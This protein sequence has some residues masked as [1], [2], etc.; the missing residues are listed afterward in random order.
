MSRLKQVQIAEAVRRAISQIVLHEL[1]DPRIGIL[2]ITAVEV[3]SDLRAARVHV[4]VHGSEGDRTKALHGL[5]HARGFIQEQIAKR[6]TLRYIP[7]LRFELDDSA[8]DQVRLQQ[9][10]EEIR[11]EDSDA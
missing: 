4:S 3:A 2:T 5:V 8:S 10:I 7:V 6:V 11:R 1:N 9:R